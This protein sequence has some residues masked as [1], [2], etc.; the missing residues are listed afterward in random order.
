MS[1]K[2]RWVSPQIRHLGDYLGLA[3][4]DVRSGNKASALTNLDLAYGIQKAM[5]KKDKDNRK[6]LNRLG[7]GVTFAIKIAVDQAVTSAI[8]GLKKDGKL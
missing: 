2:L 7:K 8:K 1:K 3:I 6:M 4:I 5:A